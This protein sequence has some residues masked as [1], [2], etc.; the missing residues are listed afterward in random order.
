MKS[1][2]IKIPLF[3]IIILTLFLS[4]FLTGCFFDQR[5]VI[6]EI[7]DQWAK[8]GKDFTYQV[9]A[10]DTGNSTLFYSLTEKPKGM[11]INENG[12][13]T[14][15]PEEEQIGEYTIKVQVSN[16][17]ISK[18]RQFKIIVE[19]LYL[20]SITVYPSSLIINK[21]DSK[22]ITSVTAHYDDGSTA[23]IP[24]NVCSYKSNV[25]SVSVTAAG[26]IKVSL[27]CGEAYAKITVSYT[28]AEVTK[29]A[30]VNVYIPGGGG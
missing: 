15:S 18:Y 6:E 20:T 17:S 16:G 5:L 1:I 19:K 29:T 3:F 21:G 23:D 4:G 8:I 14:W 27:A 12:L 26:L 9:I 25:T 7:Q 2:K 22:S 13:I 10:Y 24:L 28:E 11:E 30:T